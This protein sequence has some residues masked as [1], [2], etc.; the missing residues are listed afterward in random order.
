VRR[1]SPASYGKVSPGREALR[2][3]QGGSMCSTV[4]ALDSAL[5]TRDRG[6]KGIDADRS[7]AAGA[8]RSAVASQLGSLRGRAVSHVGNLLRT[9]VL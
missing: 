4:L 7:A 3:C 2:A 9:A 5:R 8:P 1:R 6:L